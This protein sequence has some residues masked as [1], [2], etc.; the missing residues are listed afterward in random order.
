[1]ANNREHLMT[2]PIRT[3]KCDHSL[4]GGIKAPGRLRTRKILHNLIQKTHHP[5]SQTQQRQSSSN[6]TQ[7]TNEVPPQA[8]SGCNAAI[9]S[10]I[11]F[12]KTWSIHKT[13]PFFAFNQLQYL[14][15]Q[16]ELL[17]YI[18][19]NSGNLLFSALDMREKTG[20]A[21]FV[22]E[23]S[24]FSSQIDGSGVNVIEALDE[25][26]EITCISFDKLILDV[27][28]A[29]DEIEHPSNPESF[30]ITITVRPK[31]KTSE[32]TYFCAVLLDQMQNNKGN[33]NPAFTQFSLVFTKAPAVIGGLV[34]QWLERKF[35]CRICRLLLQT[36]ELRKIVN[37]SMDTMYNQAQREGVEGLKSISISLS[38]DDTR[39]LLLSREQGSSAGFLEGVEAHC[40]A[41]MKID[42]DR[43]NLNRAGCASWYLASEGKIKIFSAIWERYS[44]RRLIQAIGKYGT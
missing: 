23:H 27:H 15:Y 30:I 26:G 18:E 9:N 43:L 22:S 14:K 31:G 4:T 10:S 36:F 24:H 41:I 21:T 25:P 5:K 44:V 38:S 37:S 20:K 39:Q 19:A 33:K 16:A 29:E 42:F 17:N 11:L 2:P 8:V 28:T 12:N 3:S 32:Q 7:L 1:M 13:T 34:I 35:D 40:S 6:G